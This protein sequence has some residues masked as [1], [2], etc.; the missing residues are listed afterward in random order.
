[1]IWRERV[2]LWEIQGTRMGLDEESTLTAKKVRHVLD[3][4]QESSQG[5]K[6]RCET[7]REQ[8]G[9]EPSTQELRTEGKPQENGGQARRQVDNACG[10]VRRLG[11]RSVSP[12]VAGMGQM[13]STELKEVEKRVENG[14]TATM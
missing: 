9:N 5:A 7:S 6:E 10:P 8:Y 12:W 3:S 11:A 14:K 2:N 4:P 13:A 1:M